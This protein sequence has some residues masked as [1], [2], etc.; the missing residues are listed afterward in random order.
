MFLPDPK[1][2]D[3]VQYKHHWV[4]G[5]CHGKKC[6]FCDKTTKSKGGGFSTTA[7]CGACKA[8]A[9]KQCLE[10]A[11]PSN[12]PFYCRPPFGSLR[13]CQDLLASASPPK[14]Y[15]PL[16]VF[17]NHKSG[18]QQGIQ[19]LQ[20]LRELL[21]AEQVISMLEETPVGPSSGLNRFGHIPNLRILVCGGDG[22]AGWVLQEMMDSREDFIH[23]PHIPPMAILPLGTGNDLARVLGWG[24][25]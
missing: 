23:R 22:T 18:G 2:P 1:N 16:L 11:G 24:G 3:S 20:E 7:R 10:L 17:V 8:P 13:F 5:N 9:H 6:V 19:V 4:S 21:S 12:G 14:D 15:Q 25:G